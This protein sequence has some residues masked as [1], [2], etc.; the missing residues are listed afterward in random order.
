MHCRVFEKTI[1]IPATRG[2]VFDFFSSVEN[3]QLLTPSWLDFQI[4]SPSPV[5]MKLGTRIDYRIKLYRLPVVWKTEI[6]GWD[7]P[8]RFEDTQVKGPYRIWI[9]EHLFE[10][11]NQ[12]TRMTDRVRYR[13]RGGLLEPAIDALFVRSRLDRIFTFREEALHQLFS[14]DTSDPSAPRA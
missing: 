3:L 1:W 9:H 2:R 12:G 10:P 14:P 6:S 4:L 13:S 7:P 8:R 5:E 11:E